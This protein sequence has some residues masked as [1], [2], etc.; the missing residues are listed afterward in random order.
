MQLFVLQGFVVQMKHCDSAQ[1]RLGMHW[2][3][4]LVP[5]NLH[6]EHFSRSSQAC[7]GAVETTS[8]L[9]RRAPRRP[10]ACSAGAAASMTGSQENHQ[11][12]RKKR[13]TR[14]A[15]DRT[16]RDSWEQAPAVDVPSPAAA[17]APQSSR[18]PRPRGMFEKNSPCL[19]TSEI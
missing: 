3:G 11:S 14:T 5:A 7:A 4:A 17:P 6:T 18:S 16:S 15:F 8:L 1:Q 12:R 10:P 19:A 9:R 2:Q 13:R